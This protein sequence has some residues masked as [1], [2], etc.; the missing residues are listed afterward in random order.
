[1]AYDVNLA[2]RL[3]GLL[4]G[5]PGLVEKRM[6][7]GLAF[8]LAGHLVVS[9]SSHGGLLLRVDPTQTEALLAEPRARPFVM[10]GREMSGWLHIDVDPS[11]NDDELKRWLEHGLGY[12]RSLPP[13]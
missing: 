8:L 6:F 12:V 2:D 9:A 5:Q 11:G 13:K 1:V 4:A 3:R 7:G 10:R